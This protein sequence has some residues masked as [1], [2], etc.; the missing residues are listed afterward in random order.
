M[1]VLLWLAMAPGAASSDGRC[2]SVSDCFGLGDCV[3]GVCAC[4]A[5]ASGNPD[6]SAFAAEPV[7]WS[8]APGYRNASSPSWS[9][10]FVADPAG[11][12][13]HGFLGAMTPGW[14]N[15]T[16]DYREPMVVHVRSRSHHAPMGGPFEPVG[17]RPLNGSFQAQMRALP[18]GRGWVLFSNRG[19]GPSP[20]GLYGGYLPTLNDFGEPDGVGGFLPRMQLVYRPPADAPSWVCATNDWGAEI[21]PDGSV[22]ALFR[23]GGHHCANGSYPG[24]PAEQL[25]LVRSTCWNC[26]EDY[27]VITERPLFEGQPGGTSNEDVFLWW[28]HRGLHMVLHSQSTSDPESAPHQVRGAVAFSPDKTTFDPE[29]WVLSPTPVSYCGAQPPCRADQGNPSQS[30]SLREHEHRQIRPAGL[31]ACC[32][33]A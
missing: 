29:S 9:G 19:E 2:S 25:G 22:L 1:A 24:W 6:C 32:L 26:S 28:S 5:W 20:N 31:L 30:R 21:L 18:G 14:F 8:P 3:G 12:P 15:R 17:S 23:N 4:D 10:S 16:H 7:A 27:R 13:G 33:P 11:G